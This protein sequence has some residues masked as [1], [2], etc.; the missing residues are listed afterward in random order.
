MTASQKSSLAALIT[1]VAFISILTAN[2][3]LHATI[4][5]V[6]VWFHA[7][8]ITLYLNVFLMPFLL[9]AA[10]FIRVRRRHGLAA[11]TVLVGAAFT[12]A[13]IAEPF[14]E[15]VSYYERAPLAVRLL[16]LP[17][18]AFGFMAI[19]MLSGT[20]LRGRPEFL[21]LIALGCYIAVLVAHVLA[22]ASPWY[23]RISVEVARTILGA[24]TFPAMCIIA[25]QFSKAPDDRQVNEI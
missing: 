13:N 11:L 10:F 15:T 2:E 9:L 6:R 3:L 21:R 7:A 22:V 4:S 19:A 12:A 5:W 8:S 25:W 18:I 23:Y 1:A 20:R 14:L 24:A 16:A 17:S